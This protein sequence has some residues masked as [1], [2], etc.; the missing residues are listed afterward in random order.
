MK[1]NKNIA[2]LPI[3]LRVLL[4]SCVVLI[5]TPVVMLLVLI[6]NIRESIIYFLSNMW[7]DCKGEFGSV[8]N[9]YEII[10]E[11]SQIRNKNEKN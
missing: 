4:F 10:L 3:P 8:K 9:L 7:S 1:L 5:F 11:R 2:R 6:L